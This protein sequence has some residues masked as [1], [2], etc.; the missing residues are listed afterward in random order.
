[1]YNSLAWYDGRVSDEGESELVTATVISREF[2]I[3]VA[4]IYRM[5]ERKRLPFVDATKPWH[6]RR[7]YLFSRDAVRKAIQEMGKG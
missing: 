5:V 2:G 6:E 7:R 1:L 3:P 4:T